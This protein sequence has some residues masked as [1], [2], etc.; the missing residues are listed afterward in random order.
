MTHETPYT[1][2]EALL[3]ASRDHDADSGNID[4]TVD[5]LVENFLPGEIDHLSSVCST[6]QE[7]CREARARARA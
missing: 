3:H 5:Y 4:A 2:T 1:E 7:A 6:L